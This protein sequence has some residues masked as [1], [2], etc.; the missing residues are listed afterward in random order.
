MTVAAPISGTCAAHP[1]V[2][3]AWACQRCGTFVCPQCERRTRPDAP[4]L[5]PQCWSMREQ[6]VTQQEA[7]ES[8]RVQ[9]A[10]L[11]LGCISVFHPLL[12][13]ASLVINIRALVKGSGGKSRWMHV[14]GLAGSGFAVLI[15]AVAILVIATR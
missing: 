2:A 7:T 8:R 5:C 13:V 11:V 14:A 12:L 10:G 3:A 4:P 9:I 6:V 1:G 15:W